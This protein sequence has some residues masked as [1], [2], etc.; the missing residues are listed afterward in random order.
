MDPTRVFCPNKN[1]HARGH[2][3]QGNI[4]SIRGRN[5]GSSAM[6]EALM[7]ALGM[8]MGQVLLDRIRQR[9]FAQ[10]DHPCEGVLLDRAHEPL[11]V[12]VQMRRPRRQEDR[13]HSAGLQQPVER[14]RELRVPNAMSRK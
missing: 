9:A 8:I 11:A 13:L 2:M 6:S 14:R 4:G 12:G 7:I 5:N 10:P 3:G 1:C